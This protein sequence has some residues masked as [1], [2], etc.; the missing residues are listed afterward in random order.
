MSHHLDSYKPDRVQ[1]NIMLPIKIYIY[2]EFIFI[3]T[4]FCIKF[5]ETVAKL[6]A[7]EI[8]GAAAIVYN[9]IINVGS[10]NQL[11]AQ[12]KLSFQNFESFWYTSQVGFLER[13]FLTLRWRKS[14][15]T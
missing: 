5:D 8:W 14:K 3:F 13:F 9:Q 10:I 11:F 1:F 15:L 4:S 6:V 2:F 7:K 12:L